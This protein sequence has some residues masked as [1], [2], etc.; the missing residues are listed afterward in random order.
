MAKLISEDEE[1]KSGFE[2]ILLKDKIEKRSGFSWISYK[3]ILESSDKKL[4]YEKE[5]NNQG[6]GDYVLSLEPIN[7][8]KNIIMGIKAFLNNKNQ[9]IFS[10]EP[11]EP[12]F[13]LVLE[14]SFKGV[15]AILWIDAG[16]VD[17]SHYAWDG[18]GLRF[19]TTEDRIGSFVEELENECKG[20]INQ[21]LI[22]EDDA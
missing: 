8:I 3:I 9:N 7:E 4:V 5:N 13:E 10:F 15:T 20:L 18:F 17:T 19:F 22:K 6:A 16:N 14:K 11:I 12:S 21:A 2:L 1:V